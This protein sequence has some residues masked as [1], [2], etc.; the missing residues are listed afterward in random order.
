[1]SASDEPPVDRENAR[2]SAAAAAPDRQSNDC[3]SPEVQGDGTV[4][5]PARKITPLAEGAT[6]GR[7]LQVESTVMA[8]DEK[9]SMA[10]NGPNA[11]EPQ[12][13][14]MHRVLCAL[15]LPAGPGVC[16]TAQAVVCWPWKQPA[17]L[18]KLTLA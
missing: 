2:P 8:E 17:L 10:A 12:R 9:A 5:S 11:A 4:I 13:E 16:C 3:T 18:M 7:E 6:P 15:C 14:K 1:M